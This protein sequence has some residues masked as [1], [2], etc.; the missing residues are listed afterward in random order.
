MVT[1]S[2]T[3][4]S[5]SMTLSE[6]QIDKFCQSPFISIHL[7]TASQM[8]QLPLLGTLAF[9]FLASGLGGHFSD[10]LGACDSYQSALSQAAGKLWGL[11]L[12]IGLLSGRTAVRFRSHCDNR[13]LLPYE[14]P[15]RRFLRLRQIWR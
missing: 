11:G 3:L 14:V 10:A 4:D 13:A 8:P 12:E 15:L 9:P 6:T 5:P 7:Q 2:V 1:S